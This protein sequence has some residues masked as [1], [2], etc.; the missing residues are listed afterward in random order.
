MNYCNTKGVWRLHSWP[1]F[2]KMT[3]QSLFRIAFPDQWVRGV[4]IPWTNEEITGDDINLQEFYVYLGCQFLMA[5]FEV[6]SDQILWWYPKLVSIQ[7]GAPLR[8]QKYMSLRQ[9]ISI[10]SAMRFK[11]N[12][13]LSFLDRFHDVRQMTLFGELY[14]LLAQLPRWVDELFSGQVMPRVHECSVQTPP[15]CKWVPNHCRFRWGES[16]DVPD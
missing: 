5:C 3:E 15:S 12:P 8:L 4:L 9:L 10:N 7:E 6:I 11:T 2:S 16:R 14:C 13:P 1:K